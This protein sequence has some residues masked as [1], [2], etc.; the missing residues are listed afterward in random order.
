MQDRSRWRRGG[1]WVPNLNGGAKM[2]AWQGHQED[3]VWLINPRDTRIKTDRLA[4]KFVPVQ[5][6]QT[7]GNK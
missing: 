4:N 6:K 7:K 5:N 1:G 2:Q 3:L